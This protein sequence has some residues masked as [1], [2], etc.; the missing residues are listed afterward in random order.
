MLTEWFISSWYMVGVFGYIT[1][2]YSGG[3]NTSVWRMLGAGIAG[4]LS[5]FICKRGDK[6]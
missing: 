5:W 6:R 4:P 1:C 3:G 2:V